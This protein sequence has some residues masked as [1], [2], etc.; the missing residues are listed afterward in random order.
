MIK[1]AL[2]DATTEF[3][4]MARAVAK[5]ACLYYPGVSFESLFAYYANTVGLPMDN[6]ISHMSYRQWFHYLYMRLVFGF[7][8][9]IPGVIRIF[10]GIT[11]FSIGLVVARA[12][13]AGWWPKGWNPPQVGGLEVFWTLKHRTKEDAN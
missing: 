13:T 7:L 2:K 4:H 9:W 8:S 12:S 3:E 11:L 1:P 10:S 6:F 5:G